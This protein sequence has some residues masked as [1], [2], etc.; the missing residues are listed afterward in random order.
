[1]P[2][3]APF[4]YRILKKILGRG[5]IEPPSPD[6]SPRYNSG[7]ALEPRYPSPDPSPSSPLAP[8]ISHLRCST[9]HPPNQK[10]LDPRLQRCTPGQFYCYTIIHIS[11]LTR[12][13]SLVLSSQGGSRILAVECGRWNAGFGWRRMAAEA[14]GLIQLYI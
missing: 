11:K 9:A 4:N 3:I 6:P 14:G 10:I 8:R 5:L 12:R 7:F 13:Y 1:M 2:Q